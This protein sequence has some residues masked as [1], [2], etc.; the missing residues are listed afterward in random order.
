MDNH[1]IPSYLHSNYYLVS[2]RYNCWQ[3]LLE[4]E[5]FI[6]SNCKICYWHLWL[7]W[8]NASMDPYIPTGNLCDGNHAEA[9]NLRF[10][11]VLKEESKTS[12]DKVLCYR[13]IDYSSCVSQHSNIDNGV[14]RRGAERKK[15]SLY[16]C[17]DYSI[18]YSGCIQF[19]DWSSNLP[20]V[21]SYD[22]I[23]F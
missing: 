7:I 23:L 19:F 6:L 14:L 21:L 17:P 12:D 22:S 2:D 16:Y 11:N 18:F 20:Y 1:I 15:R 9:K 3:T 5:R 4:W 13:C 8:T 10:R